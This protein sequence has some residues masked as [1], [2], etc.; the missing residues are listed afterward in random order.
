[1]T[2]GNIDRKLLR[3]LKQL[4]LLEY[5]HPRNDT[6]ERQKFIDSYKKGELYNPQYK[7]KHIEFN[8]E[9]NVE[10]CGDYPTLPR[11]NL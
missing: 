2:I 3:I 7:Y 6:S 8:L 9:N 10:A 5:L 11:E 4:T 1:M